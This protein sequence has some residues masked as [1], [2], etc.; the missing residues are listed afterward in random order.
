MIHG[1]RGTHDGM[2]LIV[3]H[4]SGQRTIVPDLPGFG[5]G[6]VLGDYSIDSYVAW[7]HHFID[8]QKLHV[9]PVLLG[10][11]FGTIVAAAYARE[12]PK[13]I[14]RL[15]LVNPIGAPALKGPNQL[16]TQLA[17]FYYWL[18]SVMPERLAA[19]WLR[20]GIVVWVMNVTMTKS[21]EKA[22]R[23]YVRDQHRQFFSTFH[24]AASVSQAFKAS[25]SHNVSEYAPGINVPTLLIAGAQD[26]ITPLKK[27][28]QLQ[29]M[30]PHATLRIIDHVGHLTHYETPDQVAAF[31]QD[32]IKSA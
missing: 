17:L 19:R 2:D 14:S 25:V 12:F 9:P 8:S 27:Q 13:T 1:F 30:F 23:K 6:E 31:V 15:V 7:L 21:K 29:K 32:F 18:G 3:K 16:L 11:S 28:Q 4:L 22:T 10:H 5:G 20:L 26:D 24:S